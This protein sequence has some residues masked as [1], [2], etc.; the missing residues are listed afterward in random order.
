MLGFRG[1]DDEALPALAEAERP[2]EREMDP[3]TIRLVMKKRQRLIALRKM[4]EQ[5]GYGDLA[6]MSS[7]RKEGLDDGN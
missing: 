3:E 5:S 7:V 4:L 2:D 1:S 6:K